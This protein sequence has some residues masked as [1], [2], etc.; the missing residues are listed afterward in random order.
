MNNLIMK[1]KNYKAILKDHYTQDEI[2]N[3]YLV[4]FT[5]TLFFFAP[6]IIAL[7]SLFNVLI[8][9]PY[10]CFII[11]GITAIFMAFFYQE[12][13]KMFLKSIK[14]EDAVDYTFI[15]YFELIHL[16]ILIVILCVSLM[17]ILIPIFII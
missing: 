10:L 12:A 11:A 1:Y 7:V 14:K 8:M 4:S 2:Y 9:R 5:I 13:R 16:I 15:S 6:V 17:L 3:S